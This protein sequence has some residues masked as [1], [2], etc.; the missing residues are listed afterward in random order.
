MLGAAE[1]VAAGDSPLVV[2]L[3]VGLSDGTPLVVLLGVVLS[4]DVEVVGV[5]VGVVMS[6]RG[7]T[8]VRGTQVYD[9]SG[10]KPGGTTSLAGTCCGTEGSG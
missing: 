2:G 10:M 8:S 4:G 6:V 3:V 1:V 7:C 5:V 9:G